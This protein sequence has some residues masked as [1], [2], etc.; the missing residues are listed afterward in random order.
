MWKPFSFLGDVVEYVPSP[1]RYVFTLMLLLLGVNTL[2]S[3]FL[4]HH[5]IRA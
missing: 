5:P 4:S 3:S 1:Y 2:L